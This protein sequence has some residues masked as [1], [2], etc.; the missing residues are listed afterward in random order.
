MF[1]DKFSVTSAEVSYKTS[2]SSTGSGDDGSGSGSGDAEPDL[3][4]VN[5]T[6][7]IKCDVGFYLSI[8]NET[9]NEMVVTC[10]DPLKA[11]KYVALEVHM[12][13]R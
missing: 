1:C 2:D 13:S 10:E 8:A 11:V 12:T 4:F 6:A 7:T 3:I 9:T 5:D